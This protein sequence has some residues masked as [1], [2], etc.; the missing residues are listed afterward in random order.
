MVDDD[1]PGLAH[2]TVVPGQPE[3][4]R[5]DRDRNG[6]RTDVG[7]DHPTVVPGGAN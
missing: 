1:A 2:P 7:F 3:N 4:G 6:R 5:E